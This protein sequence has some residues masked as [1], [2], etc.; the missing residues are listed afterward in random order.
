MHEEHSHDM[1][2]T[3]SRLFRGNKRISLHAKRVVDI[4]NDAGVQINNTFRSFVSAANGYD[5]TKFVEQDLRNYV[6]K[7]RRALGKEEDGKALLNHFYHM[8]ELNPQFYFDIDLDDDNRIRHVFMADA[9]SRATWD[10]FGNVLCL[11]T[12]YL[13]NKY[14]MP[15]APFLVVNH[16]GKSILLGCGLLSSEDTDAFVR[17]F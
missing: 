14:D 10:S 8:R 15:F 2:P 7:S 12:T 13:T 1:S 17:L 3:K 9:G 5:N 11:G 4:N 16:H 6:A